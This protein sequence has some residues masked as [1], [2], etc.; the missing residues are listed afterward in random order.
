MYF[1]EANGLAFAIC[2]PVNCKTL[3]QNLIKLNSAKLTLSTV[4]F[5]QLLKGMGKGKLRFPSVTA[6]RSNSIFF[7]GKSRA[8]DKA[9]GGRSQRNFFRSFGL[10]F[11]LKIRRS[12]APW[13]PPLDRPLFLFSLPFRYDLYFAPLYIPMETTTSDHTSEY[14]GNQPAFSFVSRGT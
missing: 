14:P 8:S 13:T 12:R 11:S 5:P 4:H 2:G 6:F 9:G 7:S 10:Q 3:F 1:P